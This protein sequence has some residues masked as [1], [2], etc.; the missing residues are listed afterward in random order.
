MPGGVGGAAP[1]GV[2]PIPISM[3]GPPPIIF[4][5]WHTHWLMVRYSGVCGFMVILSSIGL[6]V[7]G[8]YLL[9]R[10]RGRLPFVWLL[11]PVLFG[12]LG[13][14]VRLSQIEQRAFGGFGYD[15]PESAHWALEEA[16]FITHMGA[17]GSAALFL[18]WV[19]AQYVSRRH[20]DTTKKC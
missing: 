18:V 2:P 4:T 12:L 16:K 10:S 5:P 8:I 11:L 7:T 3:T 9:V 20:R 17:I 13:T 14:Y 19:I 1:Q 15:S 6:F